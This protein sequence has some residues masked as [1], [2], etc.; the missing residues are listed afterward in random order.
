ME[1]I[2]T[3]SNNFLRYISEEANE[4]LLLPCGGVYSHICEFDEFLI[5]PD[6]DLP[7]D[8]A[9]RNELRDVIIESYGI[10]DKT[11]ADDLLL[12]LEEKYKDITRA[13][14]DLLKNLPADPSTIDLVKTYHE[15]IKL[16][17]YIFCDIIEKHIKDTQAKTSFRQYLENEIE[18]NF[19]RLKYHKVYGEK[20]KRDEEVDDTPSSRP[21]SDSQVK[22]SRVVYDSDSDNYNTRIHSKNLDGLR[23]NDF[24]CFE[25]IEHT[26]DKYNDGEK[27]E[28][29]ELNRADKYFVI[30]GNVS[31]RENKHIRWCMAKDDVTPQDIFRMTNEGPNEKGIIAKYCIQ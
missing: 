19:K 17:Y 31:F 24:V 10:N 20:R 26:T 12:K 22:I 23:E 6:E 18:K 13:A 29:M 4:N 15:L 27:F 25:E 1:G 14:E 9:F 11:L 30:K 28:V 2:E 5:D 16:Y 7:H 21:T 3:L 8:L